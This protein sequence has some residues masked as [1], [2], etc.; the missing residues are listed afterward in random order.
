[1]SGLD[2]RL[3]DRTVDN[4]QMQEDSQVIVE[5]PNHEESLI[6]SADIIEERGEQ[7]PSSL[8]AASSQSLGVYSGSDISILHVRAGL[9]STGTEANDF[10]S[11]EVSH[12]KL[13]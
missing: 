1:M 2:H 4:T 12:L 5:E 13:I 8:N 10:V 3:R 6:Q 9:A 7:S 11:I